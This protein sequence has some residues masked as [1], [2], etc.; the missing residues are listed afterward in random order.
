MNF[1]RWSSPQDRVNY[2]CSN[3]MPSSHNAHTHTH[4]ATIVVWSSP[5]S[6]SSSSCCSIPASASSA[7]GVTT[8]WLL[9]SQ[10]AAAAIE[11]WSLSPPL[12][13]PLDGNRNRRPSVGGSLLCII[14]A[15]NNNS[16][17]SLQPNACDSIGNTFAQFNT[18]DI[19]GGR[20]V[21]GFRTRSFWP[22]II[23]RVLCVTAASVAAATNTS[24]ETQSLRQAWN[25]TQRPIK[26]CA[27]CCTCCIWDRLLCDGWNRRRRTPKSDTPNRCQQKRRL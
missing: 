22:R 9:L 5:T 20:P 6:S 10:W 18:F 15:G 19:V 21:V 1:V 7:A 25:W 26:T 24:Q 4:L 2:L 3:Y 12:S 16:L 17:Q 8:W 11:T 14:M 13:W 27:N 23:N